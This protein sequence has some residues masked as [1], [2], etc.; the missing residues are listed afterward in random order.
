MRISD[1]A[2]TDA[3]VKPTWT[4]WLASF[5]ADDHPYYHRAEIDEDRDAHAEESLPSGLD[6]LFKELEA[7]LVE[8]VLVMILAGV[9]AWLL[10][11]R[12]IRQQQDLQQRR[13]QQLQQQ[14]IQTGPNNP[15]GPATEGASQTGNQPAAQQDDRGLFPPPDDPNFNAWRAGGVGH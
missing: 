4:E 5:I 2:P 6:A 10:Y 14:R 13:Q 3:K 1:R 15:G 9:L 8:S 7:R 12:Q 11:Y